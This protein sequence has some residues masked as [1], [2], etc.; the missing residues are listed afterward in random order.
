MRLRD[1]AI[2]EATAFFDTIEFNEFWA[3][4]SP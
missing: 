4:V 1:G 2:V 3:R